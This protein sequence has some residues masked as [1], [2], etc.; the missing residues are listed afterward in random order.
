VP[1]ILVVDDDGTMA[2][3]L[4][5]LLEL[6]GFTVSTTP[7]GTAALQM[8]RDDKPNMVLM[9]VHLADGDSMQVLR[10]MRADA[11]LASTKVVMTSGLDMLEECRQ[12]GSDAFILKPYAPDELVEILKKLMEN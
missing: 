9:D 3:L 12:A 7:L 4:K 5:T 1:S 10:Q 6:E 2:I 8:A 11:E